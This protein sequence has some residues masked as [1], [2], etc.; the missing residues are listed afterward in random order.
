MGFHS[1]AQK[2]TGTIWSWG[3]NTSGQLGDNTLINKSKP[4]QIGAAANWNSLSAGGYYSLA[5]STG[6]V[7]LSYLNTWEKNDYGQLGD[8]TLVNKSSPTLVATCNP[9]LSTQNAENSTISIYPNPAKTVINI[10]YLNEVQIEEVQIIDASGKVVMLQKEKNNS[11]NI[12]N[13][14]VGIYYLQILSNGNTTQKKFLK[15]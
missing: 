14:P 3:Q 12:K 4:T 15:E 5:K 9:L 11:I 13:L 10:K 6:S 7:I 2:T 8:A 1:L